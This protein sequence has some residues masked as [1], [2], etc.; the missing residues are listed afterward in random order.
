MKF[1][2]LL[3]VMIVALGAL[4]VF[5]ASAQTTGSNTVAFNG[6]TFNVSPAI[7][8]NVNIMQ[9]A[10]DPA[11]LEQPGGPNVQHTEFV[12]YNGSAVPQ[13]SF[14]GTGSIQVYSTAAF[15]GYAQ[16]GQEYQNLQN[17]LT[18]HPD[19]TQFMVPD[20]SGG[21]V[22]NL[23]YLPGVGAAQAIRARANYVDTP[24]MSG[25]SYL[26]AFRQDVS[27][28]TGNEFL[29]TF[30]GLSKDGAHY[31]AATFSLNTGLFPASIPSDFDYTTFGQTLNDYMTKSIATL[32][33]G[34]PTDFTPSLTDLD[35]LVQ[36]FSFA[37]TSTVIPP[38]ITLTPTLVPTQVNSDPTLGGLANK[39]WTLVSY[40]DSAAPTPVVEGGQPVTLLFSDTGVSGSGGCNGYDGSFQYDSTGGT[41]SFS[42]LV[43]TLIA[44]DQPILDQENTYFDALSKATS[45]VIN[46]TQLQI[47]YDGGV[48][49][50]NGA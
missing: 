37:G 22:N 12:L 47:N 36:S 11:S 42:Q 35:A 41:I 24:S 6:F 16:A 48:L 20:S 10:G 46:G 27:P 44:C 17:L 8:S 28:F 45:Y 5:P 29:Y 21:N 14:S 39:T 50:F 26:T 4:A 31:V 33:G 25:V 49:T 32:N 18:Q 38:P 43:H 23:P 7:A 15:A 19:L 34:Q 30:Q 1:K 13:D 3:L 2:T 9:T 40:G